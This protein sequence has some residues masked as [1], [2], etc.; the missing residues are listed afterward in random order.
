MTH[1]R[2][3]EYFTLKH[4]YAYHNKAGIQ[5]QEN[6]IHIFITVAI[7][8]FCH[9]PQTFNNLACKFCCH[10][11]IV[12]WN[13]SDTSGAVHSDIAVKPKTHIRYIGG[14]QV[15]SAFNNRL[16]IFYIFHLIVHVQYILHLRCSLCGIVS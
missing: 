4:L 10:A 2:V 12:C 5:Y 16:T 9:I 11:V 3:S 14:P 15:H 1:I 7:S 13:Q 8:A 6:K